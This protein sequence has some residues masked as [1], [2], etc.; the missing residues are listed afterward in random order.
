MRRTVSVLGLC[1]SVAAAQGASAQ[2]GP[3]VVLEDGQGHLVALGPGQRVTVGQNGLGVLAN[4][5]IPKGLRA[6]FCESAAVTARCHRLVG[7]IES[8][9]ARLSPPLRANGTTVAVENALFGYADLHLHPATHLAF[10]SRGGEGGLLWGRPGL[11]HTTGFATLPIDLAAC[12][13][14]KHSGFTADPVLHEARK[15]L[16]QE[17]EMHS[18]AHTSQGYPTFSNWPSA[19]TVIHQQAH[20]TMLRRAYDGGL[21]LIV[22]SATDSQ[23]LDIAWNPHLSISQGRAALRADFELK[24]ASRQFDFVRQLVSANSSWM[25]LATTPEQARTA[26]AQNKLAVVLGLELDELSMEQI[27]QLKDDYGVA[28]VVPVHLVNNSFGGAAVYDDFFNYANYLLTGRFFRVTDDAELDFALGPVSSMTI[29]V[30]GP[31]INP[32]EVSFANANY[33]SA[34]SHRNQVGLRDDYGLRRLMKAGLLVDLAHMSASA[35]D[36]ALA[37]DERGAYPLVYSHGGLRAASGATERQMSRAQYD[38]LVASGGIF[39]L[40]TGLRGAGAPIDAWLRQYVDLAVDGPTALGTDLNGMAP[41]V[42]RSEVGLAYPFSA[43][44]GWNTSTLL[45][46]YTIGANRRFNIATDGLAHTGML[47]DFVAAVRRHAQAEGTT[48]VFDQVFHSA[49][50]FI[51]TWERALDTAPGMDASLPDVPVQRLDIELGTGT[52]N[53][54]CGG[55][56]VTALDAGSDAISLPAFINVGLAEHTTYRMQLQLVPGTR[57]PDVRR[58]RFQY[59]ANQCDPFDTG[60]TWNIRTLKVAYAVT[61]TDGQPTAGLLIHKRGAPARALDRGDVWSAFTER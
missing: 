11:S 6:T 49:H 46:E 4:V 59:M 18:E 15:F 21:R 22:A 30:L 56:F 13:S 8:A 14:D 58:V 48:R 2:S 10:G 3:Q 34:E 61:G 43:L 54:K 17:I 55:V 31:L 40:G 39:G 26:I 45:P 25:A 38:R 27:L 23:L 19:D 42:E 20:V 16:T 44:T 35:T 57:L 37:A 5:Y 12:P 24:S 52:D 29:P 50:D 51:A 36:A 1:V 53:L 60:D 32:T 9:P 7:P 47:P 41:Q 28:L 33:Q